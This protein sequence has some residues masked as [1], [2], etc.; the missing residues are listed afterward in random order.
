MFTPY[1]LKS[2][3]SELTHPTKETSFFDENT[4]LLPTYSLKNPVSG[5]TCVSPNF[6]TPIALNY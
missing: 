5:T 6:F 3:L 1:Y 2:I 4:S